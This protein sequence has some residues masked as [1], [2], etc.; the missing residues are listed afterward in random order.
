METHDDL[1]STFLCSYQN[2]RE[3][4]LVETFDRDLVPIDVNPSLQVI[5]IPKSMKLKI[6]GH[7]KIHCN[8]KIILSFCKKI[9]QNL[10]LIK[11]CLL[12]YIR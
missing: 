7:D 6:L 8:K 1:L 2:K 11:I 9:D 10:I 5:S 3:F 12:V 4:L